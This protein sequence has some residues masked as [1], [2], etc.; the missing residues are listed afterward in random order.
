MAIRRMFS[1]E[2]IDSDAFLSMPSSTQ[3]LYFHLGMRADDDGV[4]QNPIGITRLVGSG[5]DDLKVLLMKR[6]ILPIGQG[7]LVVIKHWK[8][9]NLIQKDRYT[10]TKYQKELEMLELDENKAYREKSINLL[11]DTL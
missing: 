2:I 7:E 11:E 8:I 10:P 3:A 9:N 6:F 5:T 4:V 1:R